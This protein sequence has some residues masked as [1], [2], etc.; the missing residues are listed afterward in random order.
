MLE[1][2]QE[3]TEGRGGSIGKEEVEGREKQV[4]EK[5]AEKGKVEVGGR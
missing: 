5:K 4:K 3:K 1:V 2:E